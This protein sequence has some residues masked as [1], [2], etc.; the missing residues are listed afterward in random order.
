MPLE[1][2][3]RK[4]SKHWYIRGTVRGQPI[5]E[6]TGTHDKKA[7][8]AIRIKRE[9]RLLDDSIHGKKASVTF[10]EAAASYLTSGGSR[11]HLGEQRG[12]GSWSG[13]IGHFYNKPLHT[14]GQSELDEAAVKLYPTATAETRNR[15][16]YTP[17][18]AIWN[19]AV[20]NQW[21]DLRKW[22]RP[23]KPKGTAQRFRPQ[24]SGQRP[25][26]YERAAEFVLAM[27][28]APAFVMTALFYTGMR[29]S[30]L[31]ALDADIDDVRPKENWLVLASSKTGEPRGVPLHDFVVPLFAA[32]V[33]RGGRLF[34]TPRGEAYPITED[35]D[36]AVS[37]QLKSAIAGARRRSGIRD[38]SPYTARHTVS[39][40]LV[41]NGVH[42]HIKDQILGH[43]VDD[44]S[45]HYTHV[46][47]TELIAAINT[48]PI[49]S[50][51]R[52][53]PWLNDPV[54]WQRK[55]AIGT[56]VRNDLR[57]RA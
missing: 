34:R 53:A 16:C 15:Q 55:L 20:K 23:R 5:F 54:S 4:G 6:T 1:L 32:L 19:H 3:R 36:A 41:I 46:P 12:D 27:S 14:I 13:L 48:L 43:A 29:P 56:G 51:W 17:F 45:R 33:E 7:A 18:I 28:P 57:N 52:A 2:K 11:R 25:V 8:E 30:E 9:A 24:R 21:A 38:V 44:M 49:V 31:L 39:T 42:S 22:S 40:Q 47:R 50:A 26:S 10:A 37:G 35:V